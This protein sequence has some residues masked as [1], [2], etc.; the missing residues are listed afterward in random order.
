MNQN[1]VEQNSQKQF[2]RFAARRELYSSALSS[3]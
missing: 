3:I 1:A 2:E